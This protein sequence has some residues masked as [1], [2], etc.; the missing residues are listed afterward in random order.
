MTKLGGKRA[1]IDMEQSEQKEKLNE[2]VTTPSE[3]KPKELVI[4]ENLGY[5]KLVRNKISTTIKS[6]LKSTKN[7]SSCDC[8]SGC[9]DDCHCKDAY[10]ECNPKK[11]LCTDCGNMPIQKKLPIQATQFL[12]PNKGIG[13]HAAEKIK[14]G[15]FIC[16]YL[17]EVIKN[18]EYVERLKNKYEGQHNFYTTS[19][20]R[21]YVI[22]AH[23]MGNIARFINHFCSPNAE[24]QTWYVNGQPHIAIYSLNEIEKNV[25]ITY[26][27]DFENFGI[28]QICNCGSDDCRGYITKVCLL[29]PYY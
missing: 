8:K 9:D 11:C 13:I 24:A 19:L 10:I 4:S 22:D 12:T 14:K 7:M 26:D 3:S 25:E 1:S 18:E 15:T 5:K 2:T 27:Y 21:Q 17:G 28:P 23:S 29:L 20:N 16:E 6:K